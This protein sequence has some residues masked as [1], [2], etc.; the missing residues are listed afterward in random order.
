MRIGIGL[1]QTGAV[2][3]PKALVAVAQRAEELGFDDGWVLDRLLWPLEPRVP[4]PASP[5][6]K[7]PERSQ[8]VL[9]PLDTLAFVAARTERLGLGTSVLN[10]PYYNPVLLARRLA[11]IDVLS[12]GRLMVGFGTGW[13]PEEYEATG[14]EM[15]AVG[16]RTD[17]ALALIRT[18]WTAEIVSFEGEFFRVARSVIEPKP[19]RKPHPPVYWAAFTPRAMRRV[20]LASDG[21]MPAGIPLDV[22]ATMFDGIRA[23]A[24]EAGRDPGRLELV[25]R[26]NVRF[27]RKPI[28]G[29]RPPF[30]GTAEQVHA[31]VEASRALG[32]AA[33]I[34]DVQFA[35]G[36]DT[37]EGMLARLEEVHGI[38]R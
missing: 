26:A 24:R 29:A 20:A 36:S 13:S 19:V 8:R 4:Y 14:A 23:M 10:L 25:V 2:A 28:E 22:M 34:F 32:A 33:L 16:R 6:G 18:V 7:L 15:R 35:P 38:A 31:D 1:P 5:D 12:R 37:I 21:W 11:T 3:G 30:A 9:D 27:T 17:E